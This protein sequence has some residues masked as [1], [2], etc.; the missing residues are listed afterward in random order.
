MGSCQTGRKFWTNIPLKKLKKINNPGAMSNNPVGPELAIRTSYGENHIPHVSMSH[1]WVWAVDPS[2]MGDMDLTFTVIDSPLT[3]PGSGTSG[4]SLGHLL[5]GSECQLKERAL[6]GWGSLR[7]HR[8]VLRPF[9][10]VAS[11]FLFRFKVF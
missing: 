6:G 4:S 10:P 9:C 8:G 7:V 11:S 5:A 1:G 2:S 3:W